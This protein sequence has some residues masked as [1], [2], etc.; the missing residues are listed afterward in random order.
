MQH[1]YQVKF[2]EFELYN[3]REDPNETRNLAKERPGETKRLATRLM[4]LHKE[5]TQEGPDWRAVAG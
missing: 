2:S 3:L 5:V 1:V 4:A